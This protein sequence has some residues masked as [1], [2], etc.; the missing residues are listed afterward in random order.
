MRNL[1]RIQ[2][3]VY[4]TPWMIL[5]SIHESI[6][7]QLEAHINNPNIQIPMEDDKEDDI[8]KSES[9]VPSIRIINASGIIGKRLS[10]LEM[11]CGGLDLDMLLDEVEE[12]VEDPSVSEIVMLFNSPGGTVVGTPEAAEYLSKLNEKKS[13]FAY[14]DT[15]MASAAYYLGSQCTAIY[16][17]PSSTVGSVGVYAV[18]L[19]E[20][21][22]IANAGV[23]VNAISAGKY[24][25][26]GAPWK[27]MTDEERSI[28]QAEVDQI[29][30][31]F[32][33]AVK[34]KRDIKDEYL[35]GQVFN[36]VQAVEHGFADG[37][38]SS[39]KEMIE[40]IKSVGQQ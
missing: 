27:V 38:I 29:H 4:E 28:L 36:G 31:D 9:I 8:E 21:I 13:I 20:S 33:S 10:M 35:E 6:R 23:K 37:N 39:L 26:M 5:P 30:T 14:T 34:S 16:C 1:H 12:A 24:K 17:S 18:Y 22:A 3:A 11:E 2:R 25:T 19:D 32:K 7:N 15:L 40:F